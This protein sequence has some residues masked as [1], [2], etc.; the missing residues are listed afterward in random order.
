M[1]IKAG[2]T[3]GIGSGKTTV[4]KMFEVLGVPVY[5]ADDRAKDIMTEDPELV[6]AISARFGKQIYI[7]GMLQR[8]ALAEIV[9]SDSAALADLNGMVHPAVFRDSAKWSAQHSAYPYTIKEAALLFE[10]GSYQML[11][12]V[13]T[14]FAPLET[15]LARV[16]KRDG[17]SREEVMERVEKQWSDS[18]KIE[19]AQHVI[20]NDGSRELVAQIMELHRYFLKQRV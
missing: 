6:Q 13:I 18:E 14:V 4:C 9:F 10:S 8:K 12:E 15:R 20:Y 3:G 1:G 7:D 17:V 16:M 5:Y 2:I 11:D 19:K